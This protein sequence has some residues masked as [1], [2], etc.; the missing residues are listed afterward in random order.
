MALGILTGESRL[1]RHP[2]L[3]S[4]IN[5]S[6]IQSVHLPNSSQR[7]RSKQGADCK[8]TINLFVR[9]LMLLTLMKDACGGPRPDTINSH[10]HLFFEARTYEIS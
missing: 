2:H 6:W 7:I 5:S 4:K 9:P 3:L 1:Q 10:G 8:T